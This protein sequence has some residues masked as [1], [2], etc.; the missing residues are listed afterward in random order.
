M[1]AIDRLSKILGILYVHQ[2][3]DAELSTK[4]DHLSRCGFS[5]TEI[6]ELLGST[7]NSINVA[8]HRARHQKSAKRTKQ[9]SKK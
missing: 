5:N 3:G 9:K 8:L 2:L 4:A 6:A 7:A 1:K